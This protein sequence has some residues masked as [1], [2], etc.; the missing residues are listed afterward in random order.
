MGDTRLFRQRAVAEHADPR[1]GDAVIHQPLSL[2]LLVS[3]MLCVLVF[4][5]F[6][7]GTVNI[8]R[9]ESVRGYLVPVD[10]ELKLYPPRAGVLHKL[11][12]GE[13]AL[14]KSGEVLAVIID[15]MTDQLGDPALQELMIFLDDQLELLIERNALLHQRSEL[16][17]ATSSLNEQAYEQEIELL[18]EDSRLLQ[19]RIFLG[20]PEYYAHRSLYQQKLLSQ[21]VYNQSASARVGRQQSLNNAELN[22]VRR[23]QT[24]QDARANDALQRILLK[25]E[26]VLLHL[27]IAQLRAQRHELQVQGQFSILAPRDGQVNNLVHM[28]GDRV[29]PRVALLSLLSENLKLEAHMYL[30]SRALG[31][32]RKGQNVQL[33]YD[34]FPVATFGSFSAVVTS[35]A[36]APLD[37]RE[38]PAPVDVREPVY[39]VKAELSLDSSAETNLILRPGLQFTA[40]I[41]TDRNTILRRLISPFL[42]VGQKL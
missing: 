14:V 26:Q 24:L 33:S 9:S 12:V 2:R 17:R 7:A 6:F 29:D 11:N 42:K 28:S 5:L 20:E 10:G 27:S 30:P 40:D 36:F 21:Q 4:F 8:S 19:L 41:I 38:F 18:R 13:G 16:N 25:E 32:V 37:P 22:I 23:E 31:Q 34:A 35:V 15:P 3:A 1:Y 39:L